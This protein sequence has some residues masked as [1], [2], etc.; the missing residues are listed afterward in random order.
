M[1]SCPRRISRCGD[2]LLDDVAV[3]AK[4]ERMGRQLD[5]ATAQGS[6]HAVP[7]LNQAR[8][9]LS[10]IGRKRVIDARLQFEVLR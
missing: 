7:V 3:L 5:P 10:G 8:R 2:L 6:G 4:R 1:E 9:E